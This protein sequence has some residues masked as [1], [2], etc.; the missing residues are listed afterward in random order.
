ML[1]NLQLEKMSK[2]VFWMDKCDLFGDAWWLAKAAGR[3]LE[4]GKWTIDTRGY[5]THEALLKKES[6]LLYVYKQIENIKCFYSCALKLD[7]KAAIK[8]CRWAISRLERDQ[9]RAIIPMTKI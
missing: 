1:N 7:L 6:E 2:T 3:L 5:R 8:N 9:I 4:Y